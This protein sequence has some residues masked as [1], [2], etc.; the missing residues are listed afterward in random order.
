MKHYPLG[1]PASERLRSR[2]TRL[3]VGDSAKRSIIRKV[4]RVAD[5]YLDNLDDT[6]ACR[7]V[8]RVLLSGCC[9]PQMVFV[10]E[11]SFYN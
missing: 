8:D 7:L 6:L 10:F 9:K 3:C 4:G 1:L 11:R 5:S 2:L